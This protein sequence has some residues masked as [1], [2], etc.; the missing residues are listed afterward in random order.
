MLGW[1]SLGA[2]MAATAVGGVIAARHRVRRMRIYR[3]LAARRQGLGLDAT[4]L[5]AVATSS[6]SETAAFAQ[7]RI[8]T[9]QDVLRPETLAR[10]REEALAN[11]DHIE[12]SYIPLHKQGGTVAYEAL[13]HHALDCL[14]LYHSTAL[15]HWLSECIGAAVWP[16]ADHDQSSCSLLYYIEPGDHI[17]WHY[18]HNFYRGRHY[19]VLICLVNESTQGKGSSSALNYRDLQ[20]GEHTLE[21]APN[22]L[23]VFEGARIHHQV[24]ELGP[25][26]LRVM[27]SMTFATDPRVALGQELLRRIKDT[28][29]YGVRALW[30]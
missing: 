4:P 30:D 22:I 7:E 21:I 24:T 25:G 13:H 2:G 27:L 20:G 14:A 29:F 18:D 19:T 15:R 23:V 1:V 3:E 26:E 16:T 12:R 28:A 11:R 6:I 8:A 17:G 5:L 10:L 9:V